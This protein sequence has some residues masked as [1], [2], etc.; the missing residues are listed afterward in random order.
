MLE[1]DLTNK[2]KQP[3]IIF[4][5][6]GWLLAVLWFA[7][8]GGNA[9]VTRH[10]S[11]AFAMFLAIALHDRRG[12]MPAKITPND[13]LFATLAVGCV[14]YPWLNAGALAGRAGLPSQ[15]D[16]AIAGAGVAFLAIAAWRALNIG[17]AL[18]LLLAL[19]YAFGGSA[20]WLPDGLYWRGASPNKILWHY[21][22]QSEGVFGINLRFSIE[23]TMSV[24]MCAVIY[25]IARGVL[26][27]RAGRASR[28][29]LVGVTLFAYAAFNIAYRSMFAGLTQ[30]AILYATIIV[31]WLVYLLVFKTNPGVEKPSWSARLADWGLGVSTTIIPAAHLVIIEA[32]G[33]IIIGTLTLTGA[34]RFYGEFTDT[35]G[36]A[37]LIKLQGTVVWLAWLFLARARHKKIFD[38]SAV[39]DIALA[40]VIG[41]RVVYYLKVYVL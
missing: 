12:R 20:Q 23:M 27:A 6:L 31:A 14:L 41:G 13:I 4:V 35:I 32:I 24:M 7:A 16:T 8:F 37:T 30:M 34:H 33:G 40:F 2:A 9:D 3:L 29:M 28:P 36:L 1:P 18:L 5:C 39:N 19:A 25:F 15:L 10:I 26:A 11:L 17:A 38:T 22:A 21:W